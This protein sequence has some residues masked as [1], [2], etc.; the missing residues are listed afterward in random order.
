MF[1]PAGAFVVLYYSKQK[2]TRITNAEGRMSNEQKD[3]AYS[4]FLNTHALCSGHFIVLV[5]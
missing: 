4:E 3:A 5:C 1:F 2:G